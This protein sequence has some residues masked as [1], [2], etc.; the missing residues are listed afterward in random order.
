MG[1][2]SKPRQTILPHAFTRSRGPLIGAALIPIVGAM[3]VAAGANADEGALGAA[4]PTPTHTQAAASPSTADKAPVAHTATH[5]EPV[6]ATHEVTATP[7]PPP[8]LPASVTD[9]AVPQV[10]FEAYRHAADAMAHDQPQCGIPW[11]LIA[12][13]GKVESHHANE[14]DATPDGTLKSPI[15]GPVLDGS[16][17]GNQVITDTD[18]GRLD[19]DS[20]HDRAVGPMQFIP[21]TWEKYGADGNGDGKIDPQNLF[22]A[23]LTT[24]R[25]LCDG[26]LD[27]RNQASEATAVLRYNNSM[28]YVNNVLGFARSY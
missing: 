3:T 14:G 21:S 4:Q 19:G 28:D 8:P 15:Y 24:A 18:G 13:I 22:D 16:L 23:A 7:P 2:H 12:G 11:T 27:L 1:K 9:G 6:V 25:Y 10:A 26:H 17:A 20:T 5:A